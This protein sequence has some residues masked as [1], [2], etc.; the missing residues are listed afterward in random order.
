MNPKKK[1]YVTEMGKLLR[2]MKKMGMRGKVKE[3]WGPSCS[4]V[5]S[6]EEVDAM[7]RTS[8]GSKTEE[9]VLQNLIPGTPVSAEGLK[10]DFGEMD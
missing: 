9:K 1:P 7:F 5:Q 3:D 2:W 4:I 6:S 10:N 8:T